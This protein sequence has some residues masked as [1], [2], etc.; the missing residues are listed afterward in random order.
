MAR[1]GPVLPG[2]AHHEGT[3]HGSPGTSHGG[4]GRSAHRHSAGLVQQLSGIHGARPLR[5]PR[6]AGRR[7]VQ[8]RDPDPPRGVHPQGRLPARLTARQGAAG[9]N[10]RRV[11]GG[12]THAALEGGGARNRAGAPGGQRLADVSIQ[13]HATGGPTHGHT[14]VEPRLPRSTLSHDTGGGGMGRV[15]TGEG[16]VGSSIGRTQ[17]A[18]ARGR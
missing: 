10:Y 17:P 14:E 3:G 5:G 2:G 6:R 1:W 7:S 9:G 11:C 16:G 12:H 18:T 13:T 4:D 15:P 8:P